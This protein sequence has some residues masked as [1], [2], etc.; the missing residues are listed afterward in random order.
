MC[1]CVR[2]RCPRKDWGL[3]LYDAR[4][5]RSVN[6]MMIPVDSGAYRLLAASAAVFGS[7]RCGPLALARRVRH[8]GPRLA[9]AA[10]SPARAGG[11]DFLVF[12]QAVCKTRPHGAECAHRR[13]HRRRASSAHRWSLRR[14]RPDVKHVRMFNI[15]RRA[16]DRLTDGRSDARNIRRGEPWAGGWVSGIRTVSFRLLRSP[17]LFHIGRRRS[18]NQAPYMLRRKVLRLTEG[19]TER[20]G[21][22]AALAT[23]GRARRSEI[24]TPVSR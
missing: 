14:S 21:L 4:E 23:G 22:A 3:R 11:V 16:D 10:A 2:A 12:D 15:P 13:T 5:V 20:N 7:L 24:V 9:A 8:S 19:A 6:L 18:L 17:P 1:V